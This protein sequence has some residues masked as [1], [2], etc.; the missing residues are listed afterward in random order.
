MPKKPK[1]KQHCNRF[2]KDLKNG[3][4]Q[5]KFLLKKNKEIGDFR[6]VDFMTF[7]FFLEG[8]HWG[9]K[10]NASQLLLTV[11]NIYQYFEILTDLKCAF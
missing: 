6:K 1:H 5:K 10:K 2:N 3:P 8:T 11:Q 4:H 7:F 9:Q